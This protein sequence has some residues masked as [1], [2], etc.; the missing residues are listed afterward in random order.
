MP[1]Q[2]TKVTK[3]GYGSRILGSI[4]GIIIGLLL[5]VV[6]FGVLYWNE[7][8]ADMSK[9]AEDAT[10][11]AADQM[12]T[13][14]NLNSTL[15][16]VQ[17]MLKTAESINDGKFLRADK[18]LSLHRDVEM[19]AW[20]EETESESEV[21]YGGSETTTTTYSYKT[22]W[23]GMPADSSN[24]EEPAGHENP[25]MTYQDYSTTAKN[26]TIGVYKVDISQ[27]QL[28]GS[29]A[30]TLNKQNTLLSEGARIVMD[31]QYLFIGEGT[32]EQPWVGDLRIKYSALKSDVDVTVLGKLDGDRISPF[33]DKKNN[34]LYR[35]FTGTAE[36]AV[37]TLSREHKISTWIF[38][39]LGFLM[40]WI[41]LISIL[42]PISVIL[43][44]LPFLGKVSRGIMSLAAFIVSLVLSIVTI[45]ISAIVHNIWVLIII[46]AALIG[47]GYYWY[48]QKKKSKPTESKSETPVEPPKQEESQE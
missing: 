6:S 11:I 15:V 3:V 32:I 23:T 36:G 48:M 17:G 27:M 4:K 22:D 47:G 10:P 46:V 31:G 25:E 29:D 18:Y 16:S 7:G 2:I 43:D 37:A 40:M 24:F 20:I 8:R 12:N 30:I 45:I 34:K 21:N 9:V 38:R 26:G 39:V 14:A 13:D 44:V 5:F 19:Y 41:G 33:Y 35:A 42:G 1:D 28:P